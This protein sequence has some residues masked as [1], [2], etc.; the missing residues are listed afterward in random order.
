[1]AMRYGE[2]FSTQI[3]FCPSNNL[4]Q[5]RQIITLL[6]RS[7]TTEVD[8][9]ELLAARKHL[10]LIYTCINFVQDTTFQFVSRIM[11]LLFLGIT[12]EILQ[13]KY[14]L[15]LNLGLYLNFIWM[16]KQLRVN[17]RVN[18]FIAYL[19]FIQNVYGVMSLLEVDWQQ[20]I[21]CEHLVLWK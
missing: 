3:G 17:H 4:V 12:Y 6:A 19:L 16:N 14:L 15:F 11:N 1:M 2:S 5:S 8:C 18:Y 7:I 20:Q 9:K 21:T 10:K 13:R